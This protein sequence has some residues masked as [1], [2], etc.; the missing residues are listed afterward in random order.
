MDDPTCDDLTVIQRVLAGESSAFRLLVTRYQA[1]LFGLLRN[2]IRDP[3]ECEDLAQDIF[4]AAYRN[5]ARHDPARGRFSTW[6]F[7]I[8][9]NKSL[10]ALAKRRPAPTDPLPVP[11]DT[12]TPPDCLAEREFLQQLDRALDALP[13]DQRTAFVLCELTGLTGDHAAAI[14]HVAPGTIRSRVSRAKA[15]LRAALKS[16]AGDLQ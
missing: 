10:D 7:R 15:A 14:E 12:R 5:L 13:L 6:F 8:A 1:R 4:L 2:M 16:R 11:V 3:H 9:R